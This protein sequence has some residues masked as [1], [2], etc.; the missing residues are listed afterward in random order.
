MNKLVNT[1]VEII[2][3]FFLL[4]S[5]IVGFAWLFDSK[6]DNLYSVWE[7]LGS[8]LVISLLFFILFGGKIK[9]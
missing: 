3:T 5:I 2:I 6:P 1:A 8:C 4:I 7:F 9:K